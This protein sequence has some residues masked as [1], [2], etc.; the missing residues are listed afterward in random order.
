[1]ELYPNV[2][3][4]GSLFG[5]RNLYQYLF[6]GRRVVLVDSGI[7]DTPEKVILPHLDALRMRPGRLN[8]IITTHPD[9][10]HQGGNYA[11]KQVAPQAQIACGEADRAMVEHPQTLFDQRYNF[12]R[13][14]HDV[15][16][17]AEP[18]P[19]AG[20]PCPVDLS[21]TGGERIGLDDDWALEVLHVPG[22]SDG[23]LALYDRR[24][25]AAF[26]SDAIHGR[27]CPKANGEMAIPVTYYR[28]EAY[29][30]TLRFFEGLAIDRLYSGH[31]PVMEGDAI[32]DFIADSRRTVE[33]VDEVILATFNRVPSGLTLKELIEEVAGALGDWP[34]ESW[35]LA[36][37]PLKGHMDRLESQGKARQ[38]P[39]ARPVRWMKC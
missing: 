1:M 34:R 13:A 38:L 30:S 6:V 32:R 33:R 17:E 24:A 39:G 15:G 9:L 23:H 2:H 22:H 28:I 25:R 27:G 5:G 21:F 18:W 3:Q 7:A 20:K 8:L 31:W 35:S 12:L 36:M 10:D 16:F 19:E 29:L 11:V 14:E 37:F 4:I 26:V